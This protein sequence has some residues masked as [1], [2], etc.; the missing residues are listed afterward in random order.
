MNIFKKLLITSHIFPHDLDDC[1]IKHFH[2]HTHRYTFINKFSSCCTLYEYGVGTI[3]N[4][5]FSFPINAVQSEKEI[6]AMR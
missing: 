6:T 1:V 5:L 3:I 4:H 2:L